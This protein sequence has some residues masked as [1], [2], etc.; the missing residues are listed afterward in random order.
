MQV[1]INLK[2]DRSGRVQEK[3][4]DSEEIPRY[5]ARQKAREA[6]L[7]K[8]KEAVKL[9]PAGELPDLICVYRGEVKSFI[10]VIPEFND[11]AVDR[12]LEQLFHVSDPSARVAKARKTRSE[13]KPPAEPKDNKKDGKKGS[14][15]GVQ[16]KTTPGV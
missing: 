14:K 7:E 11:T 16:E 2:C 3:K 4:I 1:T 6:A 9:V 8:I 5:E 15:S 12:L 13:K 10:N